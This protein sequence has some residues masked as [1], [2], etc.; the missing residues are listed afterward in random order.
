MKM[1]RVWVHIRQYWIFLVIAVICIP[2]V[3][4]IN[5]FMGKREQLPQWSVHEKCGT[6]TGDLP[7][8]FK[9]MPSLAVETQ[10]AIYAIE[11]DNNAKLF[12]QLGEGEKVA[13]YVSVEVADTHERCKLQYVGNNVLAWVENK[14]GSV[15]LRVCVKK[16]QWVLDNRNPDMQ[17][18]DRVKRLQMVGILKHELY[19]VLASPDHYA[20]DDCGIFCPYPETTTTPVRLKKVIQQRVRDCR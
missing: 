19:H 12:R 14:E 20:W 7:I 16:I 18:L 15:T 2:A 3:F 11:T 10:R 9:V 6:A 8:V 5:I 4:L 13:N 1:E 17:L